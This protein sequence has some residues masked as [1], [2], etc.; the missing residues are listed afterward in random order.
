MC[1]TLVPRLRLGTQTREAPLRAC[2]NSSH[3]QRTS[4]SRRVFSGEVCEQDFWD[5][6]V[7]RGRACRI[8]IR[9]GPLDRRADSRLDGAASEETRQR[10]AAAG[11]GNSAR[12]CAEVPA[13][14]V[15]RTV[16]RA[17]Q[18]RR[19]P[20]HAGTGQTAGCGGTGGVSTGNF[21]AST[22]AFLPPCSS[23]A[24]RRRRWCWN[25]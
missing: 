9:R 5:K 20:R 15:V 7:C 14:S 23:P 10:I 19:A 13:D 6:G 21:S 11:G 16:Q 3:D 12:T 18:R 1:N 2:R 17:A 8:V 25:W 4:A 22:F 24:P